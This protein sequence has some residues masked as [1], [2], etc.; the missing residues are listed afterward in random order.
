MEG[1]RARESCAVASGAS[2][3]WIRKPMKQ[4]VA[5][6]RLVPQGGCSHNTAST[7]AEFGRQNG[8]GEPDSTALTGPLVMSGG[9]HNPR[10]A[11]APPCG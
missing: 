5:R 1:R 4:F 8:L 2:V 10:R 6:L 3:C 7:G 11:Q 9:N